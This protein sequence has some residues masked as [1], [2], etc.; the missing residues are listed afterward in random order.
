MK[1]FSLLIFT[2]LACTS[3]ARADF[4]APLKKSVDPRAY[5][6]CIER[7]KSKAVPNPCQQFKQV[8]DFS[9]YTQCSEEQEQLKVAKIDPCDSAKNYADQTAYAR[10]LR[11]E[12]ESKQIPGA[13]GIS[14]KELKRT[15]PV[16]DSLTK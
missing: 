10:C 7:Q 11:D 6:R 9:A 3:F 12:K 5:A 14:S 15:I 4:C 8:G 1:F 13:A 2:F 16:N